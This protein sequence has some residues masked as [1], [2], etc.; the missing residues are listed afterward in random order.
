[1]FGSEA[2]HG[3]FT[4]SI[5]LGEYGKVWKIDKTESNNII[6][7]LLKRHPLK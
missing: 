3:P 6:Y 7:V 5:D 1:M 2:L 4:C